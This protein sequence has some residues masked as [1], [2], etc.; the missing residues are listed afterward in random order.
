MNNILQKIILIITILTIS[1][2]LITKLNFGSIATSSSTVSLE[3]IESANVSLQNLIKDVEEDD[4]IVNFNDN[5]ITLSNKVYVAVESFL[6]LTNDNYDN[7]LSVISHNDFTANLDD[8]NKQVINDIIYINLDSI[9]ESLGYS[10]ALI[11]DEYTLSRKFQTKRLI[12]QNATNSFRYI[13]SND[14]LTIDNTLIVQ[15]ST[16]KNAYDTYNNLINLGYA[17]DIDRVNDIVS[18]EGINVSQES[19]LASSHYTWGGDVMGFDEYITYLNTLYSKLNEVIVAVFDTGINADHDLF[20]NRLAE[21]SATFAKDYNENEWNDDNGHG[22][23]VSG[24]IADVTPSN[25]KILSI[26]ILNNEGKGYDSFILLGYKYVI[27]L[28]NGGENI[29]AING[30]Y[31]GNNSNSSINNCIEQLIN[32][33]VACCYA[34][35]NDSSNCQNVFPANISKAITVSAMDKKLKQANYSNYGELIDFIAPGT[36]ILSAS[37]TFDCGY[38]S[39]SGTSMATPH[40]TAVFALLQ[41]IPTTYSLLDYEIMVKSDAC[42]DLGATGFDIYYGYGYIDL[43]LLIEDDQLITNSFNL[44]TNVIVTN[45]I[46]DSERIG[47]I[48]VS[49]INGGNATTQIQM[50]YAQTSDLSQIKTK[51]SLM[52]SADL[53]SAFAFV[54]WYLGDSEN[55]DD[56][57]LISTEATYNLYEKLSLS[58]NNYLFAK[59]ERIVI[60]LTF[61]FAYVNV[62][63]YGYFGNYDTTM[64]VTYINEYGESVTENFTSGITA[65]SQIVSYNIAYGKPISISI[66][67]TY[68]SKIKY[69]YCTASNIYLL[70]DGLYDRYN[71]TFTLGTADSDNCVIINILILV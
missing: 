25:V 22:T 29:V 24:T 16:E 34:A 32:S 51:S 27:S 66:D 26:K 58:K 67:A 4:V 61:N 53:A 52:L 50:N 45:S 10:Y 15:Y 69:I 55:I 59:V 20:K 6:N 2:C 7:N 18:E 54:G 46:S 17:V 70:R 9:C 13:N 38:V 19:N 35:G 11:D 30:S 65:Q 48:Y 64:E 14:Y 44:S 56:A 5:Y 31:G 71:S 43:S 49:Y 41:S 60:K 23:H 68:D 3:E 62:D 28:K 42:V 47:S 8:L 21:G 57:D 39:K 12:V 40:V 33:N 36:D 63:E 1:T 37:Q